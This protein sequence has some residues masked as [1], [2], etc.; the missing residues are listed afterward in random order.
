[1]QKP[2]APGPKG[3]LLGGNYREITA[4][5]LGTMTR[6]AREYGDAYS[7]RMGPM[8]A[9]MVSDPALIEEVLA[10]KKPIFKKSSIQHLIRPLGGAGI[11]LSEGEFWKRQ[12]RLV[13]PPFHRQQLATYA[14]AMVAITERIS[15]KLEDG[16]TRDVFQDTTQLALEVV[17]R[18]LFDADVNADAADVGR[19]LTRAME[20]LSVRLHSAVPLPEWVPTPAMRK[21]RAAVRELDAVVYGFIARRR[22]EGGG[23]PRDLLTLLLQARD[24]SDGR[25]MTDEQVRDEAMTLFIAG[26]ETT[27]ITLAWALWLLAGHPE[28]AARLRTEVDTVLEGRAPTAQDL[29][30]LPFTDAVVKETLRLYPPAWALPREV[31]EDFEIGGY[32][33]PKGWMVGA[34]QWVTHRDP[35]FWERPD[36]FDPARWESERVKRL[37]R[38]AYFPFG[39]GPRV[40]IGNAF[41]TMEA[42]IVI[43]MLASRFDFETV[44]GHRPVP[45][46]GFTLRPDPGVVLRVRRVR[47]RVPSAVA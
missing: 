29:P 44:D 30:R 9:V 7:Y 22:A 20:A 6:Y 47:A 35:R 18:I 14:E 5:W 36:E 17:A 15:S 2:L 8:R 41:A 24:E 42:V 43:A 19:A 37:P 13:S 40:C 4:D 11:F 23:R 16:E 31:L 1:M 39:G 45:H 21:L 38:Y 10:P 33:V 46:P 3:T 26:F 34:S 32:R 28:A 12:R 25:G 27:A